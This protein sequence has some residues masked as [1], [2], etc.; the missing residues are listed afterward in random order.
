M[1]NLMLESILQWDQVFEVAARREVIF[2]L[3]PGMRTGWN[4][5][6]SQVVVGSEYP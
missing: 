5:G 4:A 6:D 1:L 2:T 3:V